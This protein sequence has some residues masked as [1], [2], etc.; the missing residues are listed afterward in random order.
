M[1][2]YAILERKRWANFISG[3]SQALFEFS[4]QTI[5]HQTRVLPQLNQCRPIWMLVWN[6]FSPTRMS[7]NC[8]REM[9]FIL[10]N[11]NI[12]YLRPFTLLIDWSQ[13]TRITLGSI[14]T[15]IPDTPV[16]DSSSVFITFKKIWLKNE[17]M[18]KVCL[19]KPGS[20]LQQ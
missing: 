3:Y 19:N 10:M 20:N 5:R 14:N 12:Q 9:L 13:L 17:N 18:M 7:I 1:Y 16:C 15:D 11:Y 4:I 8:F 2:V 6:G